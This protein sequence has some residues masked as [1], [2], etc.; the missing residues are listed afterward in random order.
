MKKRLGLLFAFI[1]TL[2]AALFAA[3]NEVKYPITVE[4]VQG[5]LVAL[6][7][8]EAKA[9]EIVTVTCTPDE[10]FTYKEGSL[11]VNGN[12]VDGTSFIMPDKAVTVTA[13]FLPDDYTGNYLYSAKVGDEYEYGVIQI[14][15]DTLTVGVTLAGYDFVFYEDISY[16]FENYE[17]SATVNG[18]AW[19][20]EIGNGVV[21]NGGKEYQKSQTSE[22]TFVGT[23]T[24]IQ[25]QNGM[26]NGYIERD[27]TYSEEKLAVTTYSDDGGEEKGEM[28]CKMF[29]N[30]VWIDETAYVNEYDPETEKQLKYGFLEDLGG[31]Y[32]F[33]YNQYRL[34]NDE[35][36]LR[37]NVTICP[38]RGEEI[39]LKEDGAYI[40]QGALNP[41]NGESWDEA[42]CY[43]F[44]ALS[45]GKLAFS[46]HGSN[47]NGRFHYFG[48]D[49]A[50]FRFG[51]VLKISYPIDDKEYCFRVHLA[52]GNTI[53]LKDTANSVKKFVFTKNIDFTGAYGEP[54]T[55][56]EATVYESRYYSEG[57]YG[58]K[59]YD[60]ATDVCV[61]TEERGTYKIYGNLFVSD[62]G[63]LN[64]SITIG[65]VTEAEP[66]AE[67]HGCDYKI[68][69]TNGLYWDCTC[70]GKSEVEI[71]FWKQEQGWMTVDDH[72]IKICKN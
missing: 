40:L 48:E 33:N 72:E 9:G 27:F 5:G 46:R 11:K 21:D 3:C 13:L 8:S 20:A 32:G 53:L 37:D 38:K 45:D 47:S 54:F 39:A 63:A 30:F 61:K 31:Y 69:S 60:K 36:L 25:E 23:F 51:N 35:T 71:C 29:G 58:D 42:V 4:N 43:D 57:K 64:G 56:E 59:Y 6:S 34:R 49:T 24:E 41:F 44:I 66:V 70:D 68:E 52:D 2:C 55:N 7:V 50:Y 18:E 16:T 1:C 26:Q 67:N 62:G 12:P 15:E 65:R 10:G 22:Q 28:P 19:T 17:I 14:K